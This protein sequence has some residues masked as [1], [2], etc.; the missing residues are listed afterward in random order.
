MRHL[1]RPVVLVT[2]LAAGCQP[3][4]D[5]SMAVGEQFHNS[6]GTSVDL[7]TT[8]LGEWERV[9]VVG[10]YSSDASIA[11]TL[12]FPWPTKGR[13]TIASNEGVTLLLFVRQGTVTSWVEHP[14]ASGDFTNISG[15][16]FER[17]QA[18]FRQVNHPPKGWAGLFPSNE[19]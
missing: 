15:R 10:P 4:Q 17:S 19:A 3:S 8:V 16:C 1:L 12:G 9:C 7:G 11:K 14:R 5:I 18:K 6:G 2:L 13:S